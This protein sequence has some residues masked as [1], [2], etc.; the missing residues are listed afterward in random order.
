MAVRNAFDDAVEAEP[1]KV[2]GQFCGGIVGWIEA[3]QLR[4]QDAHF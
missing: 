3:Q 4:Q 2:V 1:A